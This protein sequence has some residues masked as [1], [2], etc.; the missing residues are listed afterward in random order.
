MESLGHRH[1]PRALALV[2]LLLAATLL[3]TPAAADP[4]PGESEV[5]NVVC[6]TWNDTDG[7]C[8]DYDFGHDLT[9]SQ[10]WVHGRYLFDMQ[11]TD[12]VTLTLEWE[13]HEFN[14]S[15]LGLQDMDLGGNYSMI[16]SGAPADYIRNYLVMQTIFNMSVRDLMLQE[17]SDSVE[18]LVRETYGGEVDSIQTDYVDQ[19]TMNNVQ[20]ECTEDPDSDSADELFS[21]SNNA[22]QPPICLRTTANIRVDAGMAGFGNDS[23]LDIERTYQGLLTMGGAVTTNMSLFSPAGHESTF[24]VDPPSYGTIESV[25]GGGSTPIRQDGP[26]QYKI[27]SWTLSNLDAAAGS[28]DMLRDVSMT[29]T[30]RDAVPRVV[31]LDLE[32]DVGLEASATLDL[33]DEMAN[34]LTLEI[35]MHYLP[36]STLDA[37]GIDLMGSNID[38]PWVTS[39]GFR[40][41]YHNG[42]IDL[43]DFSDAIPLDT[44]NDTIQQY[45]ALDVN[46]GPL[47][48]LDF[49]S[50]GGLNFSYMPGQTCAEGTP[51]NYCLQGSNAMNGTYPVYMTSVSDPFVAEPIAVLNDLFEQR[52]GFPD[53][54]SLSTDDLAAVLSVLQ[55]EFE[56]NTSFIEGLIPDD[57]P[58]TDVSLTVILPEWVTSTTGDPST[59]TFHSRVGE[60]EQIPV[61]VTG[62]DPYHARWSEAIC[63]SSAVCTDSS[64]DLL[65]HSTWKTCISITATLDFSELN[66]REWSRAVE[67]VVGGSIRV[68]L[69]RLEVPEPFV[70]LD[71][72]TI[73][74][75]PS[76]L[77]RYAISVGDQTEGGLSALFDENLT[78]PIGDADHT[79]KLSNSGLQAFADELASY[80]TDEIQAQELNEDDI[81][82]DFAG[83]RL[84]ADVDPLE[85][86]PDTRIDDDEPLGITL[87]FPPTSISAAWTDNGLSVST[88]AQSLMLA[89][90]SGITQSI[91]GGMAAQS[92]GGGVFTFPEEPTVVRVDPVIIQH[93]LD[94][95][96]DS[97]GDGVADNDVD[98]EVRPAVTLDLLL[99][100]GLTLDL[101][102]AQ[103]NDEYPNR[104]D[105]RQQIIY[106]LPLCV[107]KESSQ[108]D[109]EYDEVS[110]SIT[111]G[112]DFIFKELL[113]YLL[114]AAGLILLLL[115]VRKRKRREKE[116]MLEEKRQL[117]RAK[118]TSHREVEQELAGIT[119][120]SAG[121]A[122]PTKGADAHWLDGID[123]TD[124]DWSK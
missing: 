34:Q 90:L 17:I 36:R 12:S 44:V 41:A 82:M 58:P 15:R 10:E 76:D 64:P 20:I 117:A 23:E 13:V 86:P 94:E 4:P 124:D 35:G 62:Q 77:L 54:S 109:A 22:F 59:I 16:T 6:S 74:A 46:M 120:R 14:R 50:T 26:F 111:I 79:L 37:W 1:R 78:V 105:G 97:D 108:C 98:I 39:D 32:N 106:R 7:I 121:P 18:E 69:Y 113:P 93:D 56:V 72:L 92:G 118:S 112:Y 102:S 63:E 49:N 48:W 55:Y 84:Y 57:L 9:S 38:L 61:G 43:G 8:D 21:L 116:K 11:S 27:G 101:E 103:G 107:A 67:L 51:V 83:L 19:V 40:L 5:T 81:S 71:G 31:R 95:T 47:T 70:D 68:E 114:G 66:V 3:A 87:D 80:M 104:Q 2:V 65:C 110:F 42:L 91:G 24:E 52:E 119:P 45:S 30:S 60:S 122:G 73:E 25:D 115:F 53:L 99:P 75:I 85:R 88:A 33:R 123:M 100:V 29:T 96:Y 89:L 28:D